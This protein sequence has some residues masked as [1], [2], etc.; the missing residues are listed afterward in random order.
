MLNAAPRL[1]LQRAGISKPRRIT[2]KI[3]S[4]VNPG[5]PGSLTSKMSRIFSRS[6][7]AL[8]IET[9]IPV[10]MQNADAYSL[11]ALAGMPN[12]TV[13][14]KEGPNLEPVVS[15]G[16]HSTEALNVHL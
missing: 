13:T 16:D 14:A 10:D 15:P 4:V 5:D 8:R 2:P 7:V 3:G 1:V 6:H 12:A 11:R 9:N